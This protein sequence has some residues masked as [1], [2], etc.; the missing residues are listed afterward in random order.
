MREA[1]QFETPSGDSVVEG[2][3]VECYRRVYP[4]GMCSPIHWHFYCELIYVNEGAQDITAGNHIERLRKGDLIYINPE[5]VHLAYSCD[6]RETVLTVLKFDTRLLLSGAGSE[7]DEQG[8][9]AF[10]DRSVIQCLLFRS[11]VL[12]GADIPAL[13]D[14]ILLEAR[15]RPYAFETAVRWRICALI[16]LL[17][18]RLHEDGGR[19]YGGSAIEEPERERFAE[20]LHY[21]R[22]HFTQ[23]IAYDDLRPICHLSYSNFAVKFKRFTGRSLT[24]YVNDLR[25]SHAQRLL[26]TTGAPITEIAD[27]CGFADASYFTRVFHRLCG[28][29]PQAF[30]ENAGRFA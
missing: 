8:L 23:P 1:I 4:F 15:E 22:A 24:G 27:A 11:D 17:A 3:P 9:H 2:Y 7:A 6:P 12:R 21:I 28:Q 26:V 14:G 29:P 25:I 16:A 10:L 30:R 18:R 19:I 20:A 13:L 5:Q